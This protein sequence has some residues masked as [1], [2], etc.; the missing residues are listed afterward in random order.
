MKLVRA[1]REVS[2]L[3][4][5]PHAIGGWSSRADSVFCAGWR[6]DTSPRTIDSKWAAKER[7]LSPSYVDSVFEWVRAGRGL[8][9]GPLTVG[10]ASWQGRSSAEAPNG[11]DSVWER[12]RAGRCETLASPRLPVRGV[13]RQQCEWCAH[14]SPP[15]PEQDERGDE[16]RL[17]P[18]L[19]SRALTNRR[20]HDQVEDRRTDDDVEPR[21]CV[22]RRPLI[23]QQRRHAGQN[24]GEA[25]AN[26][27]SVNAGHAAPRWRY[28]SSSRKSLGVTAR[29]VSRAIS[30]AKLRLG[31]CLPAI[32]RLIVASVT[33]SS[34]ASQAR[35]FFFSVSQA[36]SGCISGTYAICNIPSRGDYIWRSGTHPEAALTM[37]HAA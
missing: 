32:K 24:G 1:G 34:F 7:K 35:V 15:V 14:R 33:P 19:G 25:K 16:Q 22:G 17:V 12:V 8:P 4:A 36:S 3:T 10:S 28:E 30:A 37:L 5:S 18:K 26:A 31:H 9:T 27:D 11:T 2:R 23:R 21:Q 13:N 20:A 6:E 29:F